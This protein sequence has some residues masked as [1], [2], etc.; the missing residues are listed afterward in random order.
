MGNSGGSSAVMAVES[1]T[2]KHNAFIFWRGRVTPFDLDVT[3]LSH[4]NSLSAKAG[5]AV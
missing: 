1:F 2:F 5:R 3:G 4:R